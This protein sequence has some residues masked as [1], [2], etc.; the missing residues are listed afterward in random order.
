MTTP[1][2][3]PIRELLTRK[4]PL[5]LATLALIVVADR[6]LFY[7][8]AGLWDSDPILH[9]KHRPGV[10]RT[11]GEEFGNKPIRI[12]S[13]GFHDDEFPL[14]KPAGELRGVVIGDSVVMGHGV[15]ASEAFPNRLERLFAE[16][17]T[18]YRSVQ[19][20][21]AG[22][23]GYA[24]SQYL[25]V[26]KRSMKFSPDFVVVVFCMNDVTEPYRVDAEAGGAGVDYHGVLK[27]SRRWVDFVLNDTGL[28][29]LALRIRLWLARDR[30]FERLEIFNVR[31]MAEFTLEKPEFRGAWSRALD[32]LDEIYRTARGARL[33]FLLVISP[34]RFQI[35][36]PRFQVPQQ[37]LRRHAQVNGIAF[38]DL[39]EALERRAAAG[40]DVRSLFF[41]SVH[42]TPQG[43]QVVA[44]EIFERLGL[45]TPD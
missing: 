34:Y 5:L 37:L 29:R 9:F 24:T 7:F 2:S 44:E 12:N 18:R 22:V 14:R 27:T 11:W 4:I 30:Y 3:R 43:H 16:R 38:L 23:Q 26:L 6:T 19:V 1:P 17:T 45:P 33:P 31:R 32:D 39:T 25:E 8:L 41:D 40:A 13:H 20:I 42:Y 35:G 15:T 28:G 10:V 21:N 36:K